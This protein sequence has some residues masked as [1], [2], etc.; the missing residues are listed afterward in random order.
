MEKRFN[1]AC[2]LRNTVHL[3]RED[4]SA[5]MVVRAL[6][7]YYRSIF[8]TWHIR[9]RRGSWHRLLTSFASHS[10]T[11]SKAHAKK[12]PPIQS[13]INIWRPSVQAPEPMENILHRALHNT[14]K[15]IN[16]ISCSRLFI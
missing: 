2:S 8:T 14:I 13:N 15:S 7:D 6:V 1:L 4:T 5:S 9:N 11:M 16:T 3:K 12:T 10:E